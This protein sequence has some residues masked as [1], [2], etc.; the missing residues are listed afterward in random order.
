MAIKCSCWKG[1][2]CG[3]SLCGGVSSSIGTLCFFFG[4][5]PNLKQ[6]VVEEALPLLGFISLDV[7]DFVVPEAFGDAGEVSLENSEASF[8]PHIKHLLGGFFLFVQCG[9]FTGVGDSALDVKVLL[10]AQVGV[11]MVPGLEGWHSPM[12]LF[13][14][15]L[16][17]GK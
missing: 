13:G 6:A 11:K 16:I 4:E 3:G 15:I 10:Q 12:L 14:E 8:F 5:S 17:I 1:G 7:L 9:V 2:V